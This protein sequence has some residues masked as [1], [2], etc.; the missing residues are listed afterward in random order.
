MATITDPPSPPAGSLEQRIVAAYERLSPNEKRLAD[1]VQEQPHLLVTHSATELTER[2]GVSK[3]AGTRFFRRLGFEN[4]EEARK[5]VR[6]A[7]AWGS[8]VYLDERESRPSRAL[9]AH[10]RKDV[11][12]LVRTIETL[13]SEDVTS[14]AR[15][16]A[17]ARRVRIFGLRNS[18]IFATYLRWQLIMVRDRVVI[19]P[20]AGETAAEYIADLEE[21]DV[22]VV[23]A[24]RRR[25]PAVERW[26]TAMARGKAR[27]LLVTDRSGQA[28]RDKATWTIACDVRSTALFDSYVSV[29]S[30]L[31]LLSSL[32]AAQLGAEGRK[33]L[34][35]IEDVHGDLGEL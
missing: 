20:G 23:I 18:H 35:A 7:R 9:E 33:R 1:L 2:A 6:D 26:L 11:D 24:V 10:L 28:L 27:V 30:V 4:F 5:L 21:Q 31:N 16:L 3:A 22:A 15:A 13:P 14:I 25:P 19:A 34:R 17:N 29:L 32:V 12:N 8:P